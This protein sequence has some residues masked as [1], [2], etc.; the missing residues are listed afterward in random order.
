MLSI[1]V[2]C[3]LMFK[4]CSLESYI[5]EVTREPFIANYVLLSL[6]TLVE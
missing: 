6:P 1:R 5:L 3:A 2:D 4:I